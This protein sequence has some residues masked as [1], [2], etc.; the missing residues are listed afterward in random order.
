MSIARAH[1]LLTPP[2]SLF[3][4]EAREIRGARIKT[5]K[6]APPSLGIVFMMSAAYADR[7]FS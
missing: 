7:T 5:W 6:N 2:G 4:V 1:E 3:E